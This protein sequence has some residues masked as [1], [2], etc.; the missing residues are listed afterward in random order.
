MFRAG[1][2]YNDFMYKNVEIIAE[3]KTN[4]PFG[5]TSDKSWDELFVIANSVG[6]MLSIHT[7]PRWGGSF[8]LIKKAKSLTDK[9]I[10]AKGIHA[11]DEDVVQAIEAG[12]DKVL[13]V[14]RVPLVHN[15]KCIIEPYTISELITLDQNVQAVWNSR[16]LKTGGMK[17]E[18]FSDARES[19]SG[20]LCQASNIET[21]ADIQK[22]ANAILVGTN[23]EK[24]AASLL[25]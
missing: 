20:W 11:T 8:D 7:D 9:P 5:W 14:G 22:G 1:F 19:F 17:E 23:I 16:D 2:V 3:V 4:S 21:I 12:A 10:L 18:S 25:K 24:F 13:V 6:D 15:E